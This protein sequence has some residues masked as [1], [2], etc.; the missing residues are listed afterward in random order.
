MSPSPTPSVTFPWRYLFKEVDAGTAAKKKAK[1]VCRHWR[2]L[3]HAA[4][5]RTVCNTCYSRMQRV[6]NT[7]R[8][9]FANLRR[10]AAMRGIP[11]LI[12]FEEFKSWCQQHDYIEKRGNARWS[13]TID[14]ID[15]NK[16][17]TLDNIRPLTNCEN[18]AK[19]NRERGSSW[20]DDDD[21]NLF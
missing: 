18:V 21:E 4:D 5:K 7:E 3:R 10:S 8:Y 15:N 13:M 2:C 9:A 1:G 20:Y 11:V 14:R 17:Y 12:T 6:R 19:G 16:P